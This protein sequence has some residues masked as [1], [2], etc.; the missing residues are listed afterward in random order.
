MKGLVECYKK[1]CLYYESARQIYLESS[2]SKGEDTEW[3]HKR[4]DWLYELDV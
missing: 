4:I 3:V 2:K 1:E